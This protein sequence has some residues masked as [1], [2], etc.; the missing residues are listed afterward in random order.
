[1][2]FLYEGKK[3]VEINGK[4]D[5]TKCPDNLNGHCHKEY[6]K[7]YECKERK[8]KSEVVVN[9]NCMICGKQLNRGRLFVCKECDGKTILT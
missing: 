6:W 4:C 7:E 5:D 1:M 2:R 8:K 3:W 9:G